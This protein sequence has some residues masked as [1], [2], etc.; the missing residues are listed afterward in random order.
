[1]E[2]L[3]FETNTITVLS[4][5]SQNDS[6]K[7]R[8]LRMFEENV[9]NERALDMTDTHKTKAKTTVEGLGKI[10]NIYCI[11]KIAANIC[12]FICAF[13]DIES[14]TC[15]VIYELCIQIMDCIT[16]Q[17]FTCWHSANKEC[18]PHLPCLFLNMIQHVFVQQAKFLAANTLNT[19]KVE[20]GNNGSILNV[21]QL[22]QTVE[23][24][25]CFFRKMSDHV[26]E[27]SNPDS[28]LRFTPCYVLLS[29]Q[30]CTVIDA[31]PAVTVNAGNT[32][33]K[34][35]SSPPSTPAHERR[36]KKARGSNKPMRGGP[37]QAK[38]GLFHAKE[39]SSP[40]NS[41]RVILKQPPVLSSAPRT[42]GAI[43]LVRDTLV[44]TLSN[45]ITS[46]LMTR[47]NPRAFCQ[48]W[49]WLV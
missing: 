35:D 3:L 28:V 12:G 5:A 20:H 10:E 39:E 21:K 43:G 36:A 24:I 42:R 29:N 7:L 41:S 4:F 15:P 19:N 48:N 14:S 9:Q 16:Q 38:L 13:F 26:A 30:V 45:E 23:Y 11:V 2:S 37:D 46:S 33:K 47:K 6:T 25:S 49:K 44:P 34:Q 40:K 1:M 31:V 8:V 27:D 18:L 22:K 32:R 17:D